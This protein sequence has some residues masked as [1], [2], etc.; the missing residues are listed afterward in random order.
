MSLT[1]PTKGHFDGS[2]T[3]SPNQGQFKTAAGLLYD[4][5]MIAASVPEAVEISGGIATP[6]GYAGSL[7]IETEAEASSDTLTN[8]DVT[9][10]YDG[11]LIII[12]TTDDARDIIID[13]EAGGSGQI[14][15]SKA[16][17]LTLETANEIL[18][19]RLSGA[20]W[21]EVA[22]SHHN[23]DELYYSK[24]EIDAAIAGIDPTMTGAAIKSA[25]EA[26]DNTNAFTD[27][28]AS[29]LS[30]IGSN[31]NGVRTISTGDPTGGSDGD[32]HFKV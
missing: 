6:T 8:I 15:L 32:I 30:G 9:N 18:V 27:A 11:A 1:L 17:D 10:Y 28:A 5:T 31:G 21:C 26:E 2:S 3:P 22:H 13:H 14:S 29:K 12:K 16:A 23:H 25:Y 7:V 24:S 20:T 19:L 4:L